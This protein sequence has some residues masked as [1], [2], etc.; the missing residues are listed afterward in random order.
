MYNEWDTPNLDPLTNSFGPTGIEIDYSGNA[1]GCIPSPQVNSYWTNPWQAWH[2]LDATKTVNNT[3]VQFHAGSSPY[4]SVTLSGTALQVPAPPDVYGHGGTFTGPTWGNGYSPWSYHPGVNVGSSYSLC[5]DNK[6]IWKRWIYKKHGLPTQ[7]QTI[8]LGGVVWPGVIDQ[9]NYTMA[10]GAVLYIETTAPGADEPG[11]TGTWFWKN[12]VQADDGTPP[13]FTYNNNG[14]DP[15]TLGVVGV[16]TGL[17]EPTD[18]KCWKNPRCTQNQNILYTL[19]AQYYLPPN[20]D[21]SRMTAVPKL[22]GVVVQ[23]GGSVTITT[24]Q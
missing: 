3:P 6:V 16:Q 10:K 17:A 22:Q 15:I 23:P 18:K 20:H 13:T 4:T 9:K 2:D 8:P 11:M 24:Q 12:Y 19:N 14:K 7:Y 1:T 5:P 21:G